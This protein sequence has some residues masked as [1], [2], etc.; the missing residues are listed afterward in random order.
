MR[1][2]FLNFQLKQSVREL[3]G[4][5][6]N[7]TYRLQKFDLSRSTSS[8]NSDLIKIIF[9]SSQFT[10]YIQHQVLYEIPSSK[11]TNSCYLFSFLHSFKPKIAVIID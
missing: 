6:F 5:N 7:Y 2:V 8:K 10:E 1:Q 4:T 11:Y 9:K 3:R